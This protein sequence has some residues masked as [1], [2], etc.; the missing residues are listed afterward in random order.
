[1]KE[2]IL[3]SPL[4]NGFLKFGYDDKGNLIHYDNKATLTELQEGFLYHPETFPL[5]TSQL[6]KFAGKKGKID[7]V[8]SLNFDRF[9]EE[10]GYKKGK[11]KA[12]IEWYKL[13]KEEW[14]KAI[15]KIKSYK[16]NCYTKGIEMI[17]PERYL[18][19]KRFNDE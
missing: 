16:Y 10:Y 8:S 2:F 14:A 19:H 18:K 1:M 5:K 13:T 9:W 3:T 7:E 17:Y 12:E 6:Q 4:L 11:L 15:I